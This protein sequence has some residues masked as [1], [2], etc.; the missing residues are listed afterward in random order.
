MTK[1]KITRV[2]QGVDLAISKKANADFFVIVTIGLDGNGNV[3]IL[4]V[5]R[6]R[7]VSFHQQIEMIIS[8]AATWQPLKIGV[9][10]N[11]Y[12]AVLAEELERL[13]LLPI[14]ELTTVRDKVMRAQQRSA[15]VE[16]GRVY[17]HPSMSE[18]ISEFVLF[19]DGENDDAVDG[20]DF[21]L[22]VS[23]DGQQV[24]SSNYFIPEFESDRYFNQ[25]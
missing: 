12:Q 16:S 21:A 13:T 10:V 6:Q 2:Y 5:F 23:E 17:V 20:F 22:T 25:P 19:P 14:I 11:S 9:E 1:I 24:A 4:D 18:V 7:A 3:Y 8:K 15:L